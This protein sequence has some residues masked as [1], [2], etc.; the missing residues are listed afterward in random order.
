MSIDWLFERTDTVIEPVCRFI[1]SA[2]EKAAGPALE[3][4]MNDT[5][6]CIHSNLKCLPQL[7]GERQGL[8]Y[9]AS[10]V[11]GTQDSCVLYW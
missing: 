8:V 6:T 1:G 5:I 2:Y 7:D 3:N 4:V 11:V 9:I 10:T